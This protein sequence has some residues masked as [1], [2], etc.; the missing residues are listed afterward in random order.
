MTRL[1]ASL[2]A[3]PQSGVPAIAEFNVSIFNPRRLASQALQAGMLA[4]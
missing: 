4:F 1:Q 2:L 3:T